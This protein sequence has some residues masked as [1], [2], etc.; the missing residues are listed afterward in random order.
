MS[1]KRG[2]FVSRTEMTSPFAST[3]VGELLI[4]ELNGDDASVTPDDPSA[5]P[6]IFTRLETSPP[7]D[8]SD[9][10]P[11]D[12]PD[13]IESL[14]N[15]GHHFQTVSFNS[16]TFTGTEA[17]IK[18]EVSVCFSVDTVV[19]SDDIC[20]G[21][22]K[23]GIDI[24]NIVSIQRKASNNTWI[25]SFNSTAAKNA[26]LNEPSVTIAGCVVFLGDCEN[27]VSIVKIYELPTELPDSVVI[28]RLSHYGK[29]YSFRRDR[30]AEGI[31][32]GVRTAR[33]IIA[34][35]IPSHAFIA[36]ELARIWYPSQPKTCRKCGAEGHLA[37]SCSSQR[38]HNCQQP[39][40]RFEECSLP[41]LCK[42][43]LAETHT[44]TRC[45]FIY[46]SSNV[47]TVAVTVSY[48]KAAEKGRE[49]EAAKRAEQAEKAKAE[50]AE[51]A[52]VERAEKD[53]TKERAM[54]EDRACDERA[55][56]EDR[57][58][59]EE[60]KCKE[61]EHKE[62]E[63]KEKHRQQEDRHDDHDRRDRRDDRRDERRDDRRSDRRE[64]RRRSDREGGR[65]D[66][67][68][69]RDRDR[70]ARGRSSHHRHRDDTN[71]DDS[72]DGWTTVSRRKTK[73]RSY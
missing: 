15:A 59:A 26:A 43:C 21:F 58:H 3:P 50:Q 41:P 45:P 56:K 52:R 42:V 54:S 61:K 69:D 39:G 14:R 57:A 70:S 12:V 2:A 22:D 34:K 49:F 73:S 37:A 40:H 48:A 47:S 25:V 36:G 7:P 51:N 17:R 64:D 6:E 11:P 35:P 38:C 53:R 65:S 44:T 71:S 55:K 29:V 63:R 13:A 20:I 19:T 24:D 33:M 68:R 9:H 66:R 4:E 60:K 5:T 72:D 8:N 23:A 16:W 10:H 27:R 1:G 18:K 30:L 32:N 28:G 31:F 67:E 62:K 46:Y